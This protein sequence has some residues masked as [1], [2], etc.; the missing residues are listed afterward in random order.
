MINMTG[1]NPRLFAVYMDSPEEFRPDPAHGLACFLVA[2]RRREADF[3]RDKAAALLRTGCRRFRFIGEQMKEWY[4]ILGEQDE[5]LDPEIRPETALQFRAYATCKS[6]ADAIN[7]ELQEGTDDVCL[8]CDDS[9]QI[10]NLLYPLLFDET[11]YP[12]L[13]DG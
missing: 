3:I 11:A 2:E 6:F 13:Q 12:D 1:I 4:F 8:I 5:L 9:G 7:A 10:S